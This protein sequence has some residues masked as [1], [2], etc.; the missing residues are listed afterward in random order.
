LVSVELIGVRA[1]PTNKIGVRAK[2]TNKE[3]D[4]LC[5]A[6]LV[7]AFIYVYVSC[8]AYVCAHLCV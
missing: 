4:T 1:K 3:K 2:A 8:G 5:I 6:L 7:Y